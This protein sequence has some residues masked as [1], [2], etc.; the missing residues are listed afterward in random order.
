[1]T[2][3]ITRDQFIQTLQSQA[4]PNVV[5]AGLSGSGELSTAG[6]Y[7][8]WSQPIHLTVKNPSGTTS[9]FSSTIHL[10]LEQSQWRL[11]GTD[12]PQPS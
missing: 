2:S 8:Y 10:V 1:M 11:I 4:L 5:S 7:S 12:P 6:G 9:S 3:A